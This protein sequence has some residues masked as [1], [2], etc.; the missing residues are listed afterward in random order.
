VLTWTALG[1]AQRGFDRWKAAGDMYEIPH[2]AWTGDE[3]KKI[4]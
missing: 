1:L 4:K 3:N 2:D